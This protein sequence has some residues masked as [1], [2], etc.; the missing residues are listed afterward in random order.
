MANIVGPLDRDDFGHLHPTIASMQMAARLAFEGFQTETKRRDIL[1][2]SI[3]WYK[4]QIELD[5]GKQYKNVTESEAVGQLGLQYLHPT[6]QP[7]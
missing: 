4:R 2:W 1:D 6:P 5:Y 7:G 3:S